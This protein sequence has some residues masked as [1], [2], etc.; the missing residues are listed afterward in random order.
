M[1]NPPL[2]YRRTH[3]FLRQYEN[4]APQVQEQIEQTLFQ[5]RDYLERGQAPYGLRIKRLGRNL[6]EARVDIH[7]RIV[8]FKGRDIIKFICVGNH[9]DVRICLKNLKDLLKG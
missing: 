3:P 1:V 7:L 8:F 9:E 5:I 4:Y 2:L 6:Y